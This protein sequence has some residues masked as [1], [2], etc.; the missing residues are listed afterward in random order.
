VPVKR[1]KEFA[2]V[3]HLG[4]VGL[5]SLYFAMTFAAPLL[6]SDAVPGDPGDARFNIYVLEHTYQ[7]V[8]GRVADLFSPP[9][10]YPYPFTL[11]FSDC[12][13]ATSFIYALMRSIGLSEYRAFSAWVVIGY[14]TTMWATYYALARASFHPVACAIAASLFAFSLPSLAQLGHP[15]LSFRCGV[16][17]AILYLWRMRERADSSSGLVAI[18]WL[19]LQL[20]ASVYIGIFLALLMAAYVVAELCMGGKGLGAT[21]GE[22]RRSASGTVAGQARRRGLL[23]LVTTAIWLAAGAQLAG[24]LAAS[25][26]YDLS[27]DWMEVATMLPR[28]ASYFM[29]DAL[30]DWPTLHSLGGQSVPMRHEH[31]MFPGLGAFLCFLVGIVRLGTDWRSLPNGRLAVGMLAAFVA[32]LALTTSLHG[33]S[34]YRLIYHLPGLGA[35]RA[36]ARISVV[37]AF[38][39]AVVGAV[40][41]YSL[42][43]C[44]QRIWHLAAVALGATIFIDTALLK[45]RTF[46]EKGDAARIAS[47]VAGARSK[48]NGIRHPILAVIEA[49][50]ATRINVRLDLDAMMASQQLNWP[51]IHGRSGFAP[52]GRP[53]VP[54]CDVAAEQISQFAVW[55]TLK[56][57]PIAEP[58]KD[59][60]NRMVFLGA[61]GCPLPVPFGSPPSAAAPAQIVL[62]EV[63]L[64]RKCGRVNLTIRIKN[65]TDERVAKWSEAPVRLSW[66]FVD[67][68]D[69]S[70]EEKFTPRS[71]IA[72]DLPPFGEA[73]QTI[74]TDEPE[75]PGRYRLQVSLVAEG[76]FWFHDRGMKILTSREL[77]S[78]WPCPH[79]ATN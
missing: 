58:L 55:S 37:L 3:R 76:L 24:H 64:R 72:E 56:A 70:W 62:E 60:L 45:K 65:L 79:P 77:T 78:S 10:Y 15:Q 75:R 43:R 61:A 39:V 32:L 17:M 25:R 48:A 63:A 33:I 67:V 44:R 22:V 74:E 52:M 21:I 69:P 73:V 14:F 49:P 30:P 9:M 4:H 36:V 8:S 31:Q 57:R 28:P 6:L 71:P 19:A 2:F 51:T 16:P 53:A 29:M 12:H 7:W 18:N 41:L 26:L 50:T 68:D 23:L 34:L 27:R 5:P 47:M 40:G 11:F 38:P 59:L 46:S 20:L 66:R 1:Y 13:F 54:N 42:C 35:L